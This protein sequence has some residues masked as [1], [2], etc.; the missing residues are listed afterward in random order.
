MMVIYRYVIEPTKEKHILHLPAYSEI[1]SIQNQY[2]ELCV[3][4]KINYPHIG[5]TEAHSLRV[6]MT[7]EEFIKEP[8]DLR[9]ISTVQMRGGSLVLH[10]FEEV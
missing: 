6:F 4:A 5:E 8:N 1:L 2:G 9:F 3:W 10:I 7:G